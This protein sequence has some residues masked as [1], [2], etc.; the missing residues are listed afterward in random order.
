M[1]ST[2]IRLP[3]PP[4][5]GRQMTIVR[6]LKQ[7]GEPVVAGEPLLIA[8]NERVELLLPCQGA[9]VLD[10]VDAPDGA[11][12]AAGAVVAALAPADLSPPQDASAAQ[13]TVEER[14]GRLSP[15]AR[16]IAAATNIDITKMRGSGPSGRIMKADMLSVLEKDARLA[17]PNSGDFDISHDRQIDLSPADPRPLLS[18]LPDDRRPNPASQF[19]IL[20]A[21]EPYALTAMEVDLS[22]VAA[23][24]ARL[25]SLAGRAVVPSD[26]AFV[27]AAAAQVLPLHPLLNGAWAENRLIL[28]RRV[29]LALVDAGGRRSLI[30]DAQYLSLRGI[31]RAQAAA[32]SGAAPGD[33]TFAVA[34]LGARQQWATPP[35]EPGRSA[36][37]GLGAALV[38][39]VVVSSGGADR[40][41][42]RPTLLLTLAYD[43]RVL[44]QC[45]A[46]AFLGDVKRALEHFTM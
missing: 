29:H 4:F 6:W 19:A 28:R 25:R 38:R 45:H 34:E 11:R 42:A 32:S 10:R 5:G 44:G 23:V 24:R 27:A 3:E 26:L 20:N 1:T 2:E 41:V 31:V 36:A 33:A 13:S 7:P 43:A 21:L 40:V 16:R 9:G 18:S 17:A 37:L 15:V 46:D 8:A 30:R 12:A 35:L 14:L 22:Q 39:P